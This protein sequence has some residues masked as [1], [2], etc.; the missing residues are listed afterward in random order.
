MGIKVL[1]LYPNTFGMNMLPPAIATFSAILKKQGHEV[2]VFDT[3]YYAIDFGIDSEGSKEDRLNVVP[4]TQEMEKKNLRLKDSNW[5]DDLHN[6]INEFRPDLLAL[7]CTEDMWELGIK[8]LDEIKEYKNKNNIPVVAGGVFPTFAPEICIKYNLIDLVCV[9]EGENALI[10]LCN[11]IENK[12]PYTDVTNL[13]IKKDAKIIKKNTI[14]N[15]VDVNKT[16]IIDTSL[17]EES[18]LYRPMAGKVYKMYPVETIRGCP[19]TC[20]FCNSPD[21]M[22]LYKGLGHK[23]F[24]K[25]RMDLVYKELKHFKE[26]H[27]IEYNYFWADTFL[28]MNKKEFEEFCDMYKEIH[29]PFWMQT[30]PETINDYNIKKLSEVGLHRISFG[31]EHGNEEF[32]AKILDR[33][34]KNK[35]IIERLKIPH[36]YGVQFSVNNI[37]GFPT[38]TKKLAF[39]TIELNRHIDADNQNIYAFVPFH[40]TPL[41]KMCEDLGLIKPETITKCLVD[42]SVLNMSQYPRHEIEEI[43]KCFALYVKFPKNR[44]REIERAEKNDEEGNK[45]YDKLR[46]EYLEKYMPKPDANPHGGQEDFEKMEN[47]NYRID[48]PEAASPESKDDLNYH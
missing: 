41:R 33:R 21:Q 42:T 1:F 31:V 14:S 13:W 11:K 35:D 38:E 37:T 4:Y 43:K 17:F 34:W 40:G 36:K 16:P 29:L 9:G 2:Q 26:E 20:R 25:K 30:R 22:K 24:R 45:I 39:D 48:I 6:K 3:T 18:R 23:F 15:P 46:T 10:D 27:K 12:K 5:K 47:P 32:R 7:S 19:Y 8:I 44:W 28:A